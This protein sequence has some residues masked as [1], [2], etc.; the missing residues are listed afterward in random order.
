VRERATRKLQYQTPSAAASASRT[1]L[2]AADWDVPVD[3]SI[4]A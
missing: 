1:A 2:L 3:A 4:V